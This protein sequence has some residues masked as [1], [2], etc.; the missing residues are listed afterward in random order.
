MTKDHYRFE[1]G[2]NGLRNNVLECREGMR[3]TETDHEQV[4]RLRTSAPSLHPVTQQPDENKEIKDVLKKS[5]EE[6]TKSN[7]ACHGSEGLSLW[8]IDSRHLTDMWC[9]L[10]GNSGVRSEREIKGIMHSSARGII[11]AGV[12]EKKTHLPQVGVA[13]RSELDFG[14]CLAVRV[15]FLFIVIPLT[16]R[17]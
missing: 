3:K 7:D 6:T 17:R 1:P 16:L 8:M 9:H 11:G 4:S 15:G 5:I 2:Q 14:S 13:L 10:L 12:C